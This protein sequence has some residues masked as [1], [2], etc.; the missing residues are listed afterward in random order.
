MANWWESILKLGI[1]RISIAHCKQRARMIRETRSFYQSCIQE[2]SQAEPFDWVAF[3]ELRKYSVMGGEH[4]QGF[5]DL[6][7]LFRGPRNI[8]SNNIPRESC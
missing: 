2:N 1:K 6:F 4:T 3:K 7:S 5:W 8:R